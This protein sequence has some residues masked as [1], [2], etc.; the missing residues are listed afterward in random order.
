MLKV[1]ISPTPDQIKPDNGVG[2]VVHAQYRELPTLGIALVDD[3]A[4]A[5]VVACHIVQGSM[6]RVDVLHCH[7]LYWDDLPHSPYETWHLEANQ[8]IAAAARQAHAVTVPSAWVA[9]PFRRDMRITPWV[10]GHGVDLDAWPIGQSKGYALWN[11]NRPT[12]VCDPLPA[13]QLAQRGANVVSTFAPVGA[14]PPPSLTVVGVQPHDKMRALVRGAEV[15]LATTRET[16]GIGTLEALAAGVPILG[17]RYGGTADIVEHLVSGYLAAPGDDEELWAGYQW[18]RAHP[19][20][21]QAARER[22]SAYRWR[23]VCARYAELYQ[24]VARERATAAT[25]VTVVITNYNYA[26]YV[27]EAI[28]S[29]RRQTV[30]VAVVVVDDGSTDNSRDVLARWHDTPNVQTLFGDNQ[31][32]A[33]ARNAGIA[34]AET[35]YIVCLDADDRLHPDY[36]RVLSQALDADRALGVAYSGLGLITPSGIQPNA[37]PPD[38][39]WTAQSTPANPPSN[40]IPCAAM[41]RRSMWARVG[42]YKQVYAPA[43]DTEF[44][45]RGLASGFTARRVTPEPLFEY[46]IHEG[47]A[48]RTKVYKPID[49]WHPWMRDKQYPFAAPA[50]HPVPVR[51]YADPL[52]SVVIPVWPPHV[53]HVATAIE[54]VLGQTFR[55]WEL[56][57]VPNGGADPDLSIYP[58][59]RVVHAETGPAQARNAGAAAATAPLLLYL[60][61][62]DY[63]LPDALR[64]MLAAYVE[65][66]GRYIYSD[67]LALRNGELEAHATEEYRQAGWLER[68]QHA[69]TALIETAHVRGVGG[70]DET[71]RGWEDWDFFIK[72]AISGVCGQ[73]VAQPLLVY[74][75]DTGTVREAS[76]SNKDALLAVLKD[77]YAAYAWGSEQMSSCCGGNA[78]TILAAKAAL[79]RANGPAAAWLPQPVAAANVE[80]PVVRLRFTGPQRGGVT[81]KGRV[82]GRSY[83]GGDNPMDKYADVDPRDVEHLLLLGVW[84]VV[85]QPAVA[86]A[87][88]PPPAPIAMPAP[89]APPA[90]AAGERPMLDLAGDMPAELEAQVNQVAQQARREMR[91]RG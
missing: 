14:P 91:N 62:D 50:A 85:S 30:P 77:R 57:V 29:C 53:G 76:L 21:R 61:A 40:T 65:S 73:R 67:W 43:E 15:Y 35:D 68:G 1:C 17:Y 12:D 80:S 64:A 13:Y 44:F 4:A 2:Q 20:V 18:L 86:I 52:I 38:F 27:N 82:S 74:R 33:A 8:L 28:E 6:P 32:V 9:E 5:D 31:G 41:F 23:A 75:Q 39:D 55:R 89:A 16:F 19:E 66:G 51:S 47:S 7:G 56:I 59:A 3:P 58:F 84:E 87:V 60:D 88:P 24:R 71:M 48:S 46:R 34:H 70:F 78:D 36:C 25:G 42:G 79:E 90:A 63:L 81:Y 83:V 69:I 45:T 11:K 72:L 22:A 49:L 37:W 54:S 26:G 10:I